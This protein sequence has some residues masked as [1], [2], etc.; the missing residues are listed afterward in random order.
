MEVFVKVWF[1]DN[2]LGFLQFPD[3][4][5]LSDCS[6]FFDEMFDSGFKIEK[7][8]KEEYDAY[9]GGDEIPIEDIKNGNYRI[10]DVD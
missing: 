1:K 7:S 4:E 3:E 9:Q 6:E 10:E 8:T 2:L 5:T